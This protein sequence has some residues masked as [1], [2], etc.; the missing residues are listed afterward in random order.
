METLR[1]FSR[2]LST[3][4]CSKVGHDHSTLLDQV[5]KVLVYV[6]IA[7]HEAFHEARCSSLDGHKKSR[8]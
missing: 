3:L 8:L 2:M 1:N 5:K 7:D 4:P 6:P